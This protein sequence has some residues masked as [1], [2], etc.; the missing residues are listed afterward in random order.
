MSTDMTAPYM[1]ES[2]FLPSKEGG[3]N[4]RA[5]EAGKCSRQHRLP[6]DL[7]IL[8]SVGGMERKEGQG[9]RS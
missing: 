4:T 9:E 3:K 6:P 1:I 2:S 5:E 7:D 8:V